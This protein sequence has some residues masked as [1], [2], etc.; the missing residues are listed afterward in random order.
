MKRIYLIRHGETAANRKAIFRGRSDITLNDNGM[1][2]AGDLAGYFESIEVEKIYSSP[3]RRALQT[4][5]GAF[6]GRDIVPEELIDNLDLG[7]WNG[8]EKAM[9]EREEPAKWRMW[10]TEPE[11]L[12]FPGGETLGDVRRRALGFLEKVEQSPFQTIAAVSHRS[13]LKVMIAAAVGLKDNYYWR[14]HIDNAA[15]SMLIFDQNRG[16]TLAGLNDT[17][18]LKR[19]VFEW[20]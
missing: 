12:R 14:F 1:D 8:V 5:G 20:S 19:F 10:C 4:A 17:R 16:F 6:P 13:V 9:V 2:Q 3:L 11:R 15:V 7:D 18:H